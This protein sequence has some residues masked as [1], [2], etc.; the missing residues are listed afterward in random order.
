MH[1]GLDS[2]L[3]MVTLDLNQPLAGIVR[4]YY[5]GMDFAELNILLKQHASRVARMLDDWAVSRA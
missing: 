1:H 3:S 5:D 2:H 4:L